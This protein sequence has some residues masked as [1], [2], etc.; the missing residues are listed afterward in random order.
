MTPAGPELGRNLRWWAFY[1]ALQVA[2]HL[3]L[4]SVGAFF[5][6]LL[7]H[8]IN[9]VEGWLHANGWELALLSKAFAFWGTQWLLRVRFYRPRSLASFLKEEA[10]W[11]ERRALVVS[12]FLLLALVGFGQVVPLSHNRPY[13]LAQITA[14]V[15]ST[16]WFLGDVLMAATLHE[17]FPVS[18]ASGR[19]RRAVGYLGFFAV[20]FLITVPDYFHTSFLV[21]LHFWTALLL[22]GQQFKRW[23]SAVAY[24]LIVAAPSAALLGLDPLWGA[25][26]SP[27][28][29]SN[30]PA[31]SFLLVL[32]VLSWAYYSYRHRWRGTAL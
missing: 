4:S 9:L 6:F 27:F 29:L 22:A 1:T 31:A 20:S 28:R 24:L 15:C 11:P 26:F 16:A 17:L 3:V 2:G 13:T 18:E 23:E 8:G 30:P 7:G 32:W 12:V 5:H 21:H 19:R 10:R 25:D 14:F